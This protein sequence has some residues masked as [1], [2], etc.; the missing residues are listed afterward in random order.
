MRCERCGSEFQDEHAFPV[1][2][3]CQVCFDALPLEEQDRLRVG[4]TVEGER[5]FDIM[6]REEGGKRVGTAVKRGFSWPGLLFTFAWAFANRLW[7]MGTVLMVAITAING[8]VIAFIDES[9]SVGSMV[10]LLNLGI[11]VVVGL[12][13]NAWRLAGLTRSGF[14]HLATVQGSSPSKSLAA[15]GIVPAPSLAYS[16][17]AVVTGTVFT[18]I[19]LFM[20]VMG[21]VVLVLDGDRALALS[22]WTSACISF[23]TCILLWIRAFRPPVGFLRG[24]GVTLGGMFLALPVTGLASGPGG[25]GAFLLSL[26]LGIL[27]VFLGFKPKHPKKSEGIGGGSPA[28]ASVL[29]KDSV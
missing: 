18:A 21:V 16:L 11:A 10:A 24:L 7:A 29:P 9:P 3:I 19:G 12:K 25:V 5:T 23:V 8:V 27:L 13:G 4:P 26:P 6:V 14:K 1:P 22:S 2:G 20:A 28:N 17:G 15:Q